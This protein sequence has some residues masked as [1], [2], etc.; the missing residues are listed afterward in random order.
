MMFLAVLAALATL[1]AGKRTH[2]TATVVGLRWERELRFA[3]RLEQRVRATGEE[4]IV[5]KGGYGDTRSVER[6]HISRRVRQTGLD[7]SPRW[8]T[9]A[10]EP[11]EVEAG[12][13]SRD[14]VLASCPDLSS[15]PLELAWDF[16]SEPIA[17]GQ[18]FT[19]AEG[20]KGG[21]EA[22]DTAGGR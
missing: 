6:W 13:V 10:L 18:R 14:V 20:P 17:L 3:T 22:L 21:L 12:H 4:F 8:P 9:S 19:L 2:H 15:E 1:G 5:W 7:A 11:G 16:A